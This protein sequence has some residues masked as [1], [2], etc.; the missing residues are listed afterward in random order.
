MRSGSHN[1]G[2]PIIS[3]ARSEEHTSEVQS[4]EAISYAV[5]EYDTASDTFRPG[6]MADK[7][8][9]GNDAKCGFACHTTVKT[10]DYVFTEYGH[11]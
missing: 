9:Q 3:T 1:R 11:R 4:P 6:T 10:K 5:F 8:P 2:P 7:P